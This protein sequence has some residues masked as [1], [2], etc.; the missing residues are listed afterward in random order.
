MN[1]SGREKKKKQNPGDAKQGER[2]L[3]TSGRH[4]QPTKNNNI[5]QNVTK[6][7]GAMPAKQGPMFLSE[8][9]SIKHEK[10]NQ[11][12]ALY[13]QN[14]KTG[15]KKEKKMEEHSYVHTY[16]NRLHKPVLR[17]YMRMHITYKLLPTHKHMTYI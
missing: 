10:K 17:T 16:A 15:A 9:E 11:W 8:K 12:K 7:Q 2:Q 13:A 1:R 6:L 5:H 4:C 14:K 3:V